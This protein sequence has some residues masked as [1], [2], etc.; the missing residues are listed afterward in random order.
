MFIKYLNIFILLKV[1]NCDQGNFY[2][3]NYQ[4]SNTL[5]CPDNKICIPLDYC[6]EMVNLLREA[7][8]PVHRYGILKIIF[9][10]FIKFI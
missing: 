10:Y 7:T 1:I 8:F 5:A 3:Q 4:Y 6:S 2:P 9:L